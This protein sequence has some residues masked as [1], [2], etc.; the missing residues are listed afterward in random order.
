MVEMVEATRD[1]PGT[2]GYE[3]FLAGSVCHILER[4]ADSDPVIIHLGDRFTPHRREQ[5]DATIVVL[6][7]VRR[8]DEIVNANFTEMRHETRV[9]DFPRLL[10]IL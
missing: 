9:I 5:V 10:S 6:E 1:E 7:A 8:G 4:Y 3:W 2:L